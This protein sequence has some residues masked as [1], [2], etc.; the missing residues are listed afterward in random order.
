[1]LAIALPPEELLEVDSLVT[2]WQG[3]ASLALKGR[4]FGEQK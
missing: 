4:I 1:M 2:L 3:M